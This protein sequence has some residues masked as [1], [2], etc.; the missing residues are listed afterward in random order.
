MLKAFRSERLNFRPWIL[1]DAEAFY[2]LTKD[3]GFNAFPITK[4]RQTSVD[5]ARQWIQ[6]A[7]DLHQKTGLGKIGVWGEKKN[8]VGSVG[9]TPW[10]W[11]GENL[12]DLMY[13]I[14]SSEWGHGYGT[15][16]AIAITQYAFE[17]LKL[18][19][20]TATITPD[21]APSIKLAKSLGMKFEKRITLK[22]VET[23]LFRLPKANFLKGEKK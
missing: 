17:N 12:V 16:A 11:D 15:E 13:R 3:D 2:D 1:A 23:D 22:G 6:E 7:I 14:R 5:S 21:N 18:K 9:L 10:E 4:Y 8:L 20:L 19:E